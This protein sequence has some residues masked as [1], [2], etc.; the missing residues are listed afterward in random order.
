MKTNIT[1]SGNIKITSKHCGQVFLLSFAYSFVLKISP[2]IKTLKVEL[3]IVVLI[4]EHTC[5][6]NTLT[7]Q[8]CGDVTYLAQNRSAN[9]LQLIK[10]LVSSLQKNFLK[11]FH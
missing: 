1:I 7:S 3:E 11:D 5:V 10:I 4:Y 2:A 6:Q 8:L 9:S